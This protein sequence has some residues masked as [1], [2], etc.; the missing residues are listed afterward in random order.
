MK[1][2]E[3]QPGDLTK[4]LNSTIGRSKSKD[5]IKQEL[6]EKKLNQPVDFSQ[7]LTSTLK[8]IKSKEM[9]KPKGSCEN[10]DENRPSA[11]DLNLELTNTLRRFKS[12]GTANPPN[13]NQ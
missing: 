13:I 4:E 1:T 7:D 12:K 3:R 9:S 8:R 5:I 11:G 2:N 6:F 10:S